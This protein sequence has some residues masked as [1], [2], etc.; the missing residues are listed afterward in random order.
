MKNK[1]ITM[2]LIGGILCLTPLFGKAQDRDTMSRD[3]ISRMDS[4]ELVTSKAEQLQKSD[5]ESRLAEAK[6]DRRQ[7][8]AKSK[9]AKRVEKDASAAARESRSALRAERKA[10][11]S[12]KA[13]TKQ[14]KKASD[15]RERSDRN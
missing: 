4:I 5:D 13:A 9:D 8:R 6:L 3:E 2:S 10:Q 15:A 7:T 11:K 1:Y 12:R 14:S